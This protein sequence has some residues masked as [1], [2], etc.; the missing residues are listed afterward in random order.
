MTN[1]LFSIG[2]FDLNIWNVLFRIILFYLAYR[3]KKIA[4]GL[5]NKYVRK[6]EIRIQGKRLAWL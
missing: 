6:T 5:L 2:P 1:S 3:G 4:L